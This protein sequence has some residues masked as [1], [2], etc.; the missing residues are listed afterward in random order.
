MTLQPN[1]ICYRGSVERKIPGH[2]RVIEMLLYFSVLVFT[3]MGSMF[4]LLWGLLALATLFGAWVF[5]GITRVSYEYRLDGTQF[6]VIRHSGMRSRPKAEEFLQVDLRETVILAD[7]GS[8][9]LDEAE[10][11]SATA[12][13]RRITYDVS[14]HDAARGCAVLYV[15]DSRCW[16]KIYLQPQ[17]EFLSYLRLIAREKVHC[18]DD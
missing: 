9:L 5:M 3:V 1:T 13:P 2:I 12:K 18:H 17:G 7:E 4:G 16:H 11:T 10:A 14:A 8:P 15:Q 6:S